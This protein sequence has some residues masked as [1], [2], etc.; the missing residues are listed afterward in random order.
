MCPPDM[1]QHIIA[2]IVGGLAGRARVDY[3][4]VDRPFMLAKGA[5][6]LIDLL[7]NVALV[8]WLVFLRLV[9]LQLILRAVTNT[10]HITRERA[11]M[12][13]DVRF[14][15]AHDKFAEGALVRLKFSGIAVNTCVLPEQ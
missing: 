11:Q 4:R 13:R 8:L 5:M 14:Q 12:S 7:A 15:I 1:R 10:A 3:I 9:R 2:S 6:S